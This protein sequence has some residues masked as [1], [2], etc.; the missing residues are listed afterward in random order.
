MMATTVLGGTR[1]HAGY[2]ADTYSHLQLG[3]FSKVRLGVTK[4]FENC[5]LL[6]TPKSHPKSQLRQS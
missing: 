6:Y 5:H 2:A 1:A 4:H 3:R